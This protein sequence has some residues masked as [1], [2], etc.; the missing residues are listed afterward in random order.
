MKK[1]IYQNFYQKFTATV[2]FLENF[3][4][5]ISMKINLAQPKI[6]F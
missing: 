5:S 6:K 2:K 1:F 3:S 4:K